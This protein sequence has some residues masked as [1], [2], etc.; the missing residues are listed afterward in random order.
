[1]RQ[2]KS[3][4]SVPHSAVGEKIFFGSERKFDRVTLTIAMDNDKFRREW[5]RAV[6]RLALKITPVFSAGHSRQFD[7][8]LPHGP[9]NGRPRTV[10]YSVSGDEAALTEATQLNCVLSVEYR[11][12]SVPYGVT[13]QRVP[14]FVHIKEDGTRV[15]ID[16][17]GR[18]GQQ[19][20]T[21]VDWKPADK[22]ERDATRCQSDYTFPVLY[23]GEETF[24]VT[25]R[26]AKREDAISKARDNLAKIVGQLIRQHHELNPDLF[27]LVI[28][29]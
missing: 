18:I 4:F 22:K 29:P 17:V 15:K 11:N 9:S 24:C 26:A 8:T 27:R 21:N 5:F 2:L 12:G 25:V 10:S 6:E 16:G 20:P 7:A 23:H 1:M 28:D 13:S 3:S 19:R 14:G